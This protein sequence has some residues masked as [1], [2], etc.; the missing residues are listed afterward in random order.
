MLEIDSSVGED[1]HYTGPISQSSTIK[2][3]K[4]IEYT[5][6]LTITTGLESSNLAM[7]ADS[8]TRSASIRYEE[9]IQTGQKYLPTAFPSVIS[10]LFELNCSLWNITVLSST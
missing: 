1:A 4:K 9:R 8:S 7:D 6:E 10:L 3:E 2:G 5:R